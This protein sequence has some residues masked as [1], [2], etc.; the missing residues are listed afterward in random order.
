MN[1]TGKYIGKESISVF[2]INLFVES[3]ETFH[4]SKDSKFQSTFTSPGT[5]INNRTQSLATT[6]TCH[7][8]HHCEKNIA[9]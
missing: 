9:Q 2:E 7:S 1:L 5:F 4:T 6:L 8:H 3:L